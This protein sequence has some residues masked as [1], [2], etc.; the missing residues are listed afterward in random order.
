[1]TVNA[2]PFD[3]I[4]VVHDEYMAH[5]CN[6]GT[7]QQVTVQQFHKLYSETDVLRLWAQHQGIDESHVPARGDWEVDEVLG[8][9]HLFE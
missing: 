9:T 6:M 7:L 2:V 3:D 8:S 4:T 5:C 1:M